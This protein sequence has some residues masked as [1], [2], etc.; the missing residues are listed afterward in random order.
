MEVSEKL[1]LGAWQISENPMALE[2][3]RM[4][5]IS[6]VWAEQN[7]TTIILLPSGFVPLAKDISQRLILG[8]STSQPKSQAA[9]SFV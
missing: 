2:S 7:S 3:R 9:K 5:T 1:L 8:P 4:Q 6:E